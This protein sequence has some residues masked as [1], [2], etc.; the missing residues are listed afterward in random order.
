[1]ATTTTTGD[2]KAKDGLL[3]AKFAIAVE[4]IVE[5]VFTEASG[6]EAEIE[7]FEYQEGGQNQFIHKLPGRMKYPNLTLKRGITQSMDFW[8]WFTSG[9]GGKE[10]NKRRNISI[11][12]YNQ[13]SEPV[14]KWDFKNA[15]P[16]KWSGPSFRAEE[17]AVAIES[18]EIVHE[19]M[20][21]EKEI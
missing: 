16:I 11:I 6:L 20:A 13:K 5:A 14:K 4:G 18:L 9:F 10:S 19:G 21:H 7:V 15:Y 1:M 2:R 8:M 17:N 12:L 3:S